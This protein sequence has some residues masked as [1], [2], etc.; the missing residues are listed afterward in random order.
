MYINAYCGGGIV[1]LLLLLS[2]W[3]LN[4]TVSFP[5]VVDTCKQTYELRFIHLTRTEQCYTYIIYLPTNS[6]WTTSTVYFWRQDDEG[7]IGAVCM[8]KNSLCKWV[9]H[10]QQGWFVVWNTF[11]IWAG[12]QNHIFRN[13]PACYSS[14][15]CISRGWAITTEHVYSLNTLSAYNYLQ[16]C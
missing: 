5:A 14:I 10:L 1:E 8:F 15:Y 7:Y 13:I 3:I 6:E 11:S 12:R 16:N 9:H 4:R 2:L